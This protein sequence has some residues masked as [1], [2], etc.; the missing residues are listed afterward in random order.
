FGLCSFWFNLNR[1]NSCKFLGPWQR[2]CAF[3]LRGCQAR[4]CLQF[5]ETEA[6]RWA[7]RPED[8]SLFGWPPKRI[9]G[10][11]KNVW[12]CPWLGL[13]SE[14]LEPFFFLPALLFSGC[15]SSCAGFGLPT[16]SCS[17]SRAR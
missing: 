1:S 5:L 9:N 17:C 12:S 3:A 7:L 14:L 15:L 6:K 11:R 2:Y 10:W 8:L 4:G 16:E 13:S